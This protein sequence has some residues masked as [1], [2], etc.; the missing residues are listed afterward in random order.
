MGATENPPIPIKSERRELRKAQEAIALL[1]KSGRVTLLTRR[2]FN[3]LLHIAQE[4]GAQSMYRRRL[5]DILGRA[6]FD[7]NNTEVAKEQLRRMAGIR[8][9]WNSIS[10]G[11]E[12]RWGISN[13]LAEV[14]IIEKNHT[15][16]IEWSYGEKVRAKLLD[17]EIYAR[18]SL[19]AYS[20]LRSSASAALYEICI[21]YL[22]NPSAL[23]NRAHWQWWR[24][25]LT[26]NPED[27]A[28]EIEYKFFKRD[29][30]KPAIAEVN[31][32]AD[33]R[34]ELI[35]HKDGRKVGDIQFRVVRVQ[36]SHLDLPD[37]N[38]VNT[39]VIRR[40][41]ADIGLSQEDAAKLYSDHEE[42]LLV[43]TIEMTLDRA[44][45]LKLPQLRSRAAYFRDAIRGKYAK[46]AVKVPSTPKV[47]PPPNK[48]IAL[49]NP[50]HAEARKQALKDFQ[51]KPQAEQDEILEAFVVANPAL[52]SG[53]KKN[54]AG[55]SV[56][57]ALA[58]WL[59]A[60]ARPQ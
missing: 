9:E 43:S 20:Q 25:R 2:F 24:P 36:Q 30:L 55:K 1:P 37:P 45:D 58:G 5:S 53:V 32:L 15:V 39:E 56:L 60:R 51:S 13:L 14:E 28:E 29:T 17:P 44:N 26:G 49:A 4:D 19:E 18:I 12:R 10:A 22:T 8:V 48:H 54:A 16:W 23:T 31:G 41:V 59:V 11:E 57:A 33:I 47:A 35:E 34:V 46:N 40:L 3:A 42:Q 38:L 7:S 21:R 50:E 27:T 52:R 6:A